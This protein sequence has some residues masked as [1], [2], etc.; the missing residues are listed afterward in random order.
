MVKRLTRGL[1]V[2]RMKWGICG[3]FPSCDMADSSCTQSILHRLTGSLLSSVEVARSERPHVRRSLRSSRRSLGVKIVIAFYVSHRFSTILSISSL[4]C[5]TNN[6]KQFISNFVSANYPMCCDCVTQ[7]SVKVNSD[8]AIFLTTYFC[9]KFC[10]IKDRI[11]GEISIKW[12]VFP[13]QNKRPI[14]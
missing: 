5:N 10:A 1:A 2:V 13:C 3:A 4:I 14:K 12:S 8:E 6:G 11:P 9:A 7:K